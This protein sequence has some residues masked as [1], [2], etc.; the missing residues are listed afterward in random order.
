MDIVRVRGHGLRGLASPGE[1]IDRRER[2]NVM[3]LLAGLLAGQEGRLELTGDESLSRRPMERVATPLRE[4]GARIETTD[5]HA[6]IVVEG[7]QLRGIDVKLPVA[8]AQVK[9]AVLLAGL[10]AK[11]RTTVVEP[12]ADS[13]SHR[14]A[15]AARGS[16]RRAQGTLGEPRR[17]RTARAR[18]RRSA[19]RLLVGRAADRRCDAA[20]PARSSTSTESGSTRRVPV[21]STCSSTCARASPSS[22]SA[23]SAARW[24]PTSRCA[25]P[26]RSSRRRVAPAEVP[27]MVDELP[28]VALSLAGLARG[29]SRDRKAASRSCA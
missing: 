20:R 29:E 18:P 6:P 23:S 1:P 9:S 25:P 13:R 17:C 10:Y 8:S 26:P 28:L 4:L 12:I 15:A 27:R 3:R 2:G 11:G 16:R 24:S 19:R 22:T 21:S 5:G 7:G 14:A